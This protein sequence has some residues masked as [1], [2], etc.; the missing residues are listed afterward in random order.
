MFKNLKS[1]ANR[2]TLSLRYTSFI[3]PQLEYASEV[4]GGC[5]AIDSD[6]LEKLQL[7]AARIVTGLTIFAFRE[8]LY[9]ETGWVPLNVTRKTYRLNIMNKIHNYLVPDYIQCI[10]KLYEKLGKLYHNRM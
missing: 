8:A 3:R 2:K 7:H 9:F 5:H 6:K 4:W 1:K 10:Y